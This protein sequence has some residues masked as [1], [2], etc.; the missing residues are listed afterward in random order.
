MGPRQSKVNVSAAVEDAAN[1]AAARAH[2]DMEKVLHE[3]KAQFQMQRDEQSQKM[4][5]LHTKLE[6]QASEAEKERIRQ[7]M[8]FAKELA[9]RDQQV[10]RDAMGKNEE[11]MQLMRDQMRVQDERFEKMQ[12][13]HNEEMREYQN[14]NKLDI[15][16]L[17]ETIA[18][19]DKE[20]EDVVF[21][22]KQPDKYMQVEEQNFD[23]FCSAAAAHLKDVPKMPK[24]SVA[25][26]GPSG[27]GKST[28]INAFA[29]KH[30]TKIGLS[31]CTNEVS[32]VFG[33]GPYDWY[34]VPGSH[35][36]RADFYNIEVLHKLKSL[37]MVLLVC[38]SRVD[39]VAKVA[40]LMVSVNLPFV[41]VRNKCDFSAHTPEEWK[42]CKETE[43]GKLK[44][45][46]KQEN[47]PMVH[48][49]MSKDPE[50]GGEMEGL[51]E[52]RSLMESVMATV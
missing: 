19:L 6:Q 47:P 24:K 50:N 51:S 49:G 34:D 27:V 40:K 22:P 7:E 2:A 33:D 45:Y 9:A 10:L 46:T 32:M 31:E 26:L 15:A 8:N 20:M 11:Q 1:K 35:D 48:L 25:V 4:L 14:A 21:D 52:L 43:M 44:L 5:E 13:A 30:V 17:V 28:L 18:N 38:E 42:Q 3:Q 16:K 41:V 29:G 23:K 12:A 39:H 37:H 36:A